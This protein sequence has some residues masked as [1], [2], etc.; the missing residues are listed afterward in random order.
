MKRKKIKRWQRWEDKWRNNYYIFSRFTKLLHF[1]IRRISLSPTRDL[2]DV[3]TVIL[4]K[5][6]YDE[7]LGIVSVILI[8]CQIAATCR[9][10]CL[11]QYSC[12]MEGKMGSK[13]ML[14]WL[15]WW[16]CAFVYKRPK[17]HLG[18]RVNVNWDTNLCSF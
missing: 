5:C 17:G 15:K 13:R 7:T 2:G 6:P 4:L 9:Y 1:Y 3:I 10:F 18:L 11:L 12:R 14:S 8:D 16:F